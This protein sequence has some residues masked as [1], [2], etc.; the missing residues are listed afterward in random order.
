MSNV[1]RQKFTGKRQISD[2][3]LQQGVF[4]TIVIIISIR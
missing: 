4:P 1:K 3:I 2:V